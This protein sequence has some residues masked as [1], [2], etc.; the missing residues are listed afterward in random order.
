[1]QQTHRQTLW[2]HS[3]AKI[4]AA[5]LQAH[6][7]HAFQRPNSICIQA[8]KKPLFRSMSPFK[9]EH[10]YMFWVKVQLLLQFHLPITNIYIWCCWIT[11]ER[12]TKQTKRVELGSHFIRD[13][14]SKLYGVIGPQN[15]R[16]PSPCF[17]FVTCFW[18]VIEVFF[19]PQIEHF[20][21][22]MAMWVPWSLAMNP[23]P[24]QLVVDT[25][26]FYNEKSKR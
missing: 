2:H 22:F 4:E 23:E 1:M 14:W 16:L 17:V 20:G 12:Q 24:N 7:L 9:L 19:L 11:R 8:I 15:W 3:Q 13:T 5:C 25:W 6:F 26:R 10:V 21:C 18:A